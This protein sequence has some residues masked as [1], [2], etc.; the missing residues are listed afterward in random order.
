MTR[1]TNP[2]V[3]KMLAKAQAK[4]AVVDTLRAAT[5]TRQPIK[6]QDI[7]I[8]VNPTAMERIQDLQQ[9]YKLGA[10]VQ[11]IDVA[12]AALAAIALADGLDFWIVRDGRRFQCWLPVPGSP[13]SKPKSGE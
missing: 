9:R 5:E 6:T 2:I 12:L 4:A 3:G 11:V 1:R 7:T 13:A 8:A 10:P